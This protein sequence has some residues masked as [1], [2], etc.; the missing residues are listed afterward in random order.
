MTRRFFLLFTLAMA[1]AASL[2]ALPASY[3][4]SKSRLASGR[5][6][7]ISTSSEG[8]YQ[9]DYESLRRLGFDN[10]EQVQVYGYHATAAYTDSTS[11]S[12][13]KTNDHIVAKNSFSQFFP[14][15]LQPVATHHTADGRLLFYGEGDHVMSSAYSQG[16]VSTVAAAR[17]Y[18]DTASHYFLSDCAGT[19]PVRMRPDREPST[20]SDPIETHIHIESIEEDLF[21]PNS[22]GTAF[23]GQKYDMG[24]SA[25]FT[26]PVKN[27]KK[28]SR[29]STGSFLYCFGITAKS[30]TKLSSSA[31]AEVAVPQLTSVVD[32]PAAAVGTYDTYTECS[33]YLP[34][35][36][37]DNADTMADTELT[38]NVNLPAKTASMCAVDFV[39]LR[40]PRLNAV[41]AEDPFIIMNLQEAANYGAHTI[42]FPDTDDGDI[43][44]W[45][46][47]SP[48]GP[49]A[50][51]PRYD[52]ADRATRFVLDR[53]AWRTVAFNPA[54]TTF[55]APVIEGEVAN[56]N[57]HGMAVP[58]MLIITSA[59]YMD[60]ALRL[61]EIHRVHQGLDVLVLDHNL[62]YNE[63][64]SGTRDAMAYRRLAK[65][66]HDRNTA[67]FRYL[68]FFGPSYYDNRCIISP[69][70]DRMVC[71]E[72]D[73]PLLARNRV[74]N[75]ATDSYFSFL[76]DKYDH[77]EIQYEKSDI[78]VGRVS[79]I[80]LSQASIYVDKVE[81]FITNPP[82]AEYHNRAL[83]IGGSG[84]GN[85]HVVHSHEVYQ[86][87]ALRNRGMNFS[88]SAAG[89]Y[90]GSGNQDAI[91]S[92]LKA[93]AGYMTYSG[94]GGPTYIDHWSVQTVT[95]TDYD[96]PTFAMFSSCDQFSY[97]HMRNGL[98]EAMLFKDKGGAIAG[99]AASRSVFIP[100]NQLTCLN[101]AR[102]Y[103]SSRPGDTYGD[104][105][106]R[107][108]DLALDSLARASNMPQNP[109]GVPQ[110]PF[111]N[112]LAY[113]LAGDPA[114][115][116][117][118]SEREVAV[119]RINNMRVMINGS[120]DVKPYRKFKI[121]G[122]IKKFDGS[123]DTSFDGG[124]TVSVY[125]GFTNKEYTYNSETFKYPM[126]DKM[127]A[128]M[129]GKVSKGYYTVEIL[130]PVPAIEADTYRISLAARS[131]NGIN[132]EGTFHNLHINAPDPDDLAAISTEA[133]QIK[134]FAV[135]PESMSDNGT[136]ASSP[137]LR[138]VI[139]PSVS[140]LKVQTGDINTRTRLVIDGLMHIG[141][142]EGALR[143]LDNGDYELR[144][145]AGTLDEGAHT[146]EL[147][148][149]NNV[150]LIDRASIDVLVSSNPLAAT[151]EIAE[152]DPASHVTIAYEGAAEY[153]RLIITDAAGNT[154]HS[155]ENAEF[156][157]RWDFAKDAN[158]A[159][160]RYKASLLIRSGR[161][162]G[163]SEPIHFVVV[164]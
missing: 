84:D 161:S 40:Y 23:L 24:T 2:S 27:F 73:I 157:Y 43:I 122:S 116:V 163:H 32:S 87:M 125:D 57:I 36:P 74:T 134:E 138:A 59:E 22:G 129:E 121:E 114:V 45:N 151:V 70:A 148:V 76:S 156:P 150:S 130:L 117:F 104:L 110:T 3:Y 55:P 58:D 147:I 162:Y 53:K 82:T 79:A 124:I 115:P 88:T 152:S 5:W 48:S 67:K 154:V 47:D 8:I 145:S 35:T 54:F 4:A 16:G 105:L 60:Q 160:G 164:R 131:D 153:T 98:M 63:F 56:Q 41:D 106:V 20:Y 34:F 19:V 30:E 81:H 103:A 140:G 135:E 83:L 72:Q 143:R 118:A 39:M 149:C 85:L 49:S 7:K 65:M 144:A 51:R 128:R 96:Y 120:V 10:P 80:N 13:I 17:N 28:N 26:F 141:N 109:F 14:D 100:H 139:S 159:D 94:H 112:F 9:L 123:V 92:A 69:A 137:T 61:A 18:Y 102:A 38:F 44:L 66:F 108:R 101:V 146:I 1:S 21:A 62:I 155:V 132:A 91:I 68:L 93:G 86:A 99:V 136:V 64:S 31:P 6:V 126:N 107:A 127:L 11:V 133:P 142:L 90:A 29:T 52:A 50:Y 33:G 111:R 37:L 158:V 46:I 78:A 25:P 97:D 71:Y 77:S 113:S 119:S 89:L 75:Y 42:E 15:D 95:R 12:H